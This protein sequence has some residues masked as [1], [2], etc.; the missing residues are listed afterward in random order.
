MNILA[1]CGSIRE[2][3]SNR[4]LIEAVRRLLPKNW[5]CDYF[6]IKDL[7]YFDPDLQ[8]GEKLPEVVK[9]LRSLAEKSEYILI[10][11]PEYAHGIPGILKN[12]LEWLVCEETVKKKVVIVVGTSSGGEY[13]R[14]YLTETVRTMDMLVRPDHT[15]VVRTA[16]TQVTAEGEVLDLSLQA[17]LQAFVDGFCRPG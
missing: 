8:F 11:T 10:S 7:P 6:R 17:S 9:T 12:A 16:R 14:E 1:I 2:T 13:V 5:H 15:L 4:A 3:S